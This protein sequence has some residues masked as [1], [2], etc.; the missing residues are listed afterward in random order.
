MIMKNLPGILLIIISIGFLFNECNKN[1]ALNFTTG[2]NSKVYY[3]EGD[4]MPTID[5][6]IR[7]Y[8]DYA[9]KV[10]IVNKRDYDNLIALN[11]NAD[12]ITKKIDSLKNMSIAMNIKNGELIKEI[13][14]DS[15]L[16][17]LDAQ[18][19]YCKDNVMYV[20]ENEVVSKNFYFFHCTSY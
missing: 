12:S 10:Y 14:P 2:V 9:G 19:S 4:C 13:Q 5:I 20:K 11:K 16:V 7:K 15:F 17:M 6:P 8:N 3:G 1:N 18:Y